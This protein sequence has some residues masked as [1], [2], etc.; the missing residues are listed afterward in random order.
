M[1]CSRDF[2]SKLKGFTLIE[3][4][5]TMVILS[6]ILG[7]AIP[8]YGA[9]V[10]SAR[11][12]AYKTA[13][14]SFQAAASNA[15]TH[16]MTAPS[17][18]MINFCNIHQA[19]KNQYEYNVVT[20]SELIKYNYI[21]PIVDPEDTDR[22]CDMN[23]SY[24][25]ISN[26]ANSEEEN[27]NEFVYKICLICGDRR[28]SDCRD[29]IL[30][31]IASEWK[32]SCVVSYDEAGMM[33]YDGK[34]TDEDLFLSLSSTG[35]YKYGI[36]QYR[37]Q[38]GEE[39][40]NAIRARE[41]VAKVTLNRTI[42]D[43]Q[44]HVESYDGVNQIRKTICTSSGGS[45]IKL[46]KTVIG[47]VGIDGKQTDGTHV[48]SNEWAGT[49]VILTAVVNPN[50]SVS[51]YQYIWYKDGEVISDATEVTY[52]AKTN[53]TYTVE[54][55]NGVGKQHVT[56]HP[57]VVKIDF[58]A[59]TC[60]LSASGE[61]SG[62]WYVGDVHIAFKNI[63]DLEEDGTLGSGVKSQQLSHTVVDKDSA[64]LKVT[65]TVI[66]QVGKKGTCSI[67]IKRDTAT[68][69]AKPKK[70]PLAIGK[71]NYNFTDNLQIQWGPSKG[72]VV[73]DPKTSI[74]AERYTVNCTLTSTA[75]HKQ[76]TVSFSV[77]RTYP[78]THVE[79]I[80][81]RE[82]NCREESYCVSH[83]ACSPWECTCG[84]WPDGCCTQ[85]PNTVCC[86]GDEIKKTV[87]DIESYNCSY[88]SCPDGGTLN[89][90]TCEF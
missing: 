56:S 44:I 75:N 84:S 32:S 61:M 86:V 81:T 71:K 69:S 27:N 55:T 9:Y 89:G 31:E 74:D 28:S 58:K 79:K 80:C 67:V 8:A 62:E 22:T 83:E 24:V 26:K 3:L 45:L 72:T 18:E 19:P 78:A 16:C 88:Y 90:K 64:L 40:W 65:G 76:S 5:A 23:Q 41:D 2:K 38:I 68:P 1:N 46:D 87:C 20:G 4:L 36:N 10:R 54:V 85:Y 50:K 35:N 15:L 52:T 34:W 13:E 57:F 63:S 17:D 60:E 21:D 43:K 77:G 12:K 25:Y 49:D 6:I 70:D 53:G 73:C 48:S 51:G 29:D 66:D 59:P 47:G 33:S 30:S 7:L 11:N 42:G 39:A 14:E 82:V 37:Y